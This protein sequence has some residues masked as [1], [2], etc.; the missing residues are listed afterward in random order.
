MEIITIIEDNRVTGVVYGEKEID[1]K[2]TKLQHNYTQ[3]QKIRN[4]VQAK[5]Y[6]NTRHK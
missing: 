6:N 5:A 3:V 4:Q 2:G 1:I